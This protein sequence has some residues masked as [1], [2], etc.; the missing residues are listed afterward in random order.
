MRDTTPISAGVA[1]SN[2]VTITVDEGTLGPLELFAVT[3]QVY[4]VP[5][6][7]LGTVTGEKGAVAGD[8]PALQVTVYPV[9]GDP[10]SDAGAVKAI[11][12]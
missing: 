11:E 3:A 9:I 4:V 12:T 8:A 5:F 7:R 2:G 10:P 1:A 6:I